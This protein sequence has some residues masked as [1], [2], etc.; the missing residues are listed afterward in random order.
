M[1]MLIVQLI[2]VSLTAM[3]SGNTVRSC[4]ASLIYKELH[5]ILLEVQHNF[6]VLGD[7]ARRRSDANKGL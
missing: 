2:A 6:F 5:F 7:E 3:D 4:L 1:T